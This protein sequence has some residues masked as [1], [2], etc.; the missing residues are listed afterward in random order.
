[1]PSW[2]WQHTLETPFTL[3]GVG[4]HSGNTAT[5][6]VKPAPASSGIVFVRTDIT[7]KF[8]A[9]PA[10]W[11]CVTDTRL[12]TVL[13]NRQG[14]SVSTVEHL[15]SAFAAL[16]VDNAVVDIDG[17]EIPIMDGSAADFIAA[18][19]KAGLRLQPAPRR[20]LRIKKTVSLREG[21][22]EVILS[23]AGNTYFGF[24]IAFDNAA[25]GR[26]KYTHQLKE[27][28]YRSDIASARTFGFL[29]EVE[30]LRK[31]GL[32]RGGS[33]DNAIVIDG[34][35][36]LNPG[37]LRFK[38]EFV[39]HKILDAIGDI[40]LAGASLLGHYHG[41]KAGHAMNNKA[42]HALFAQ[43]DAFEFVDLGRSVARPMLPVGGVFGTAGQPA[44][45]IA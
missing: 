43:A 5:I 4:V 27:N 36:I 19:D 42:L 11:D 10:R 41:V 14:V 24:E 17:P 37:G 3:Q 30:Q 1:M 26:Q 15:L 6:R 16:G 8:N 23:P 39:R 21:D 7:D 12:C 32:A 40:Y 38:N 2:I 18:I 9:I 22:K 35:K 45:V 33:L 25:V 20:A 31:M 44:A 13:A 34:D 28:A 29:H